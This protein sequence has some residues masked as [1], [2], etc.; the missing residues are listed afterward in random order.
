MTTPERTARR[1]RLRVAT[2]ADRDN[3]GVA[4]VFALFLVLGALTTGALVP[5]GT[6]AVANDTEGGALPSTAGATA[7]RADAIGAGTD[8]AGD[9]PP[10]GLVGPD[11]NGTSDGDG[12]GITDVAERERYGTDPAD[13]D[14]DGDGYPDGME[15]ACDGTLPDADPLHQDVYV[16]V[17]ATRG[18]ALDPSAVEHLRSAFADAP[19]ANA[20]GESG[21]AVHVRRSDVGL[22]VNGSVDSG[23]RSGDHN[24]VRDYRSRYFDSREAGYYYVVVTPEA[25]FRGDDY[26]AGAG[27]DGAAVVEPFDSPRVTGSLLMH[28]LGHAFGLGPELSGIDEERFDRQEYR[29]V[30]NYNAIYEVS[31]YSDGTDDVGRDEWSFVAHERHRPPVECEG[32]GTCAA[33]CVGE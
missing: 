32:D 15:V 28:E 24:D 21:I 2:P 13:A 1:R 23:S 9:R 27:V 12:D 14:T 8:V 29:S 6:E 20:D 22:P 16:E 31:T 10:E 30:M 5:G 19:V 33:A 25:A 18:A 17:D 7:D 11:A 4:V 3:R 26:Y